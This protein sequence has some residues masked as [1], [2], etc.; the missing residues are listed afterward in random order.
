MQVPR[1]SNPLFVTACGRHLAHKA[2]R[3]CFFGHMLSPVRAVSMARGDVVLARLGKRLWYPAIVQFIDAAT[4][5]ILFFGD[6]KRGLCSLS[7]LRPYTD[8]PTLPMSARGQG[9]AWHDAIEAADAWVAMHGPAV[10]T[11]QGDQDAGVAPDEGQAW[12][13]N[14]TVISPD[15]ICRAAALQLPPM[16]QA[17]QPHS[18]PRASFR[19]L[20][21]QTSSCAGTSAGE[22]HEQ[23]EDEADKADVE[24]DVAAEGEADGESEDGSEDETY[25]RRHAPLE[26]LEYRGFAAHPWVA[27]Q[28]REGECDRGA[29]DGSGRGGG[30][31]ESG[32]GDCEGGSSGI[33][34]D[35]LPIG[36][37]L[38]VPALIFTPGSLFTPQCWDQASPDL[39]WPLIAT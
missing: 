25:A 20:P 21:A 39:G 35:R 24:A 18:M 27:A 16:E 8:L 5:S 22:G 31:G 28:A 3:T 30:G 17:I 26:D 23:Q 14:G 4:A 11:A 9:Q 6:S 12:S 36:A 10:A 37:W 13:I 33:S 1:S 19:V 29:P 34:A 2:W 15:A 32:E 7:R 38:R